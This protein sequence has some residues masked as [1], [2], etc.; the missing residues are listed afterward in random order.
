M[1]TP[2][3]GELAGSSLGLRNLQHQ[4][5]R[6]RLSTST[7]LSKDG[8]TNPE[9]LC[10]QRNTALRLT[11]FPRPRCWQACLRPYNEAPDSCFLESLLPEA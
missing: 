5:E 10:V 9:Q 11:G 6:E 3:R 4:E 7:S 1:T 2:E 8:K